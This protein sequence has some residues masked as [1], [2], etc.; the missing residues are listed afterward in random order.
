M[1]EL[2]V[3]DTFTIVAAAVI[4]VVSVLTCF[5]SP[6]VRFKRT[7]ST[8]PANDVAVE[9]LS[10]ILTPHD[11]VDKLRANLPLLLQQDYPAKYQVIVV[12]EEGEHD[13]EDLVK[14][15]QGE[16][17]SN[18]GDGSLYMTYIPESSRYMSRKKL[19]MTLGV[20]AAKTE[21]VLFTE[22][23]CRPASPQWLQKMARH[24]DDQAH[25]VIGYGNY[26]PETPSF[27]RFERLN[28]AYYLMREDVK[29]TA[30]TTLSHNVMLRKSDFME[31][32]GFRGNLELIRGEYDFLVNKYATED[33]TALVTDDEAW[34]TDDVPTRKDFLNKHIFYAETRKFLQRS[35]AHRFWFNIDQIAIHL[36]FWLP[37]A[38][39]VYGVLAFNL[40]VFIAAVVALLVVYVLR[41]VTG[42][43]AV[44]AFGERISILYIFTFQLS[45]VWH[46]LS[47]L[48]RHRFADKLDFT[49]HKQ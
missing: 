24:C 25:L 30:Y 29:G 48:V 8:L 4:V 46:N 34:M 21:W 28:M 36:G 3:I 32:E 41:T 44:K 33:G 22:A 38:G 6:F 45:L 26:D 17:A 31:K 39:I 12:I 43:I 19:A 2:F 7:A 35:A 1:E 5:F 14:R 16:L 10:V 37:V 15:L 9:K 18:P 20:K 42:R 11:E 49:T 47:Y 13:T 27:K 40:I 23:S